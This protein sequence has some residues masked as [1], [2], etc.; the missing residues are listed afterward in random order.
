MGMETHDVWLRWNFARTRS[1]TR[2]EGLSLVLEKLLSRSA[3][4]IMIVDPVADKGA[5]DA[6]KGRVRGRGFRVTG[7]RRDSVLDG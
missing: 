5:C 3:P 2:I 1:L 7:V 4:A 6:L